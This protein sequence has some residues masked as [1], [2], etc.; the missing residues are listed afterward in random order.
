MVFHVAKIHVG[1]A[2]QQLGK[3]FVSLCHGRAELVAVYVKIVEQACKAAFRHRSLC[4]CFDMVEHT[5][6]GLI[7]IFVIVSSAVDVAE[8]FG[9]RNEKAFFL[10]QAFTSFFC[11][12]IGHLCV[13]KIGI[14]GILFT[15]VDVVG[16]IFGDI[17]VKH[18]AEDVILEI[19]SVHSATKLVC[20]RPYCTVQLITFLFFLCINHGVS[21]PFHRV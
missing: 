7:Q 5:L 14:T 21:A 12:G 4:G 19:P 6:Q 1:Y 17:S 8:Q 15:G 16:Q 20:N 13:I 3:A 11:I 2:V 18:R 10:N 9:R